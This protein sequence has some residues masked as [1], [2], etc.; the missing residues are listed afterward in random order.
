[1]GWTRF[2]GQWKYSDNTIKIDT[3]HHTLGWTN[4]MYNTKSEPEFKLWTLRDNHMSVWASR[5]A[6]VVTNLPANAGDIRDSGSIPGSGRSPGGGHGNP[7]QYSCLENPMDRGNWQA[8]VYRVAK[9][10]S[11]LK[12]P[13]MQ[14]IC[15]CRF[16]N[17]NKCRRWW[18]TMQLWGKEYTG[19]L[20]IF[21]S[22]LLGT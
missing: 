14:K 8:M 4:R 3:G 22:S 9:R 1:M 6:L 19:N 10:Q 21:C 16:I 5:V 2:L 17:C 13:S 11:W 15:Q 12:Q 7:F 20:S 18:E